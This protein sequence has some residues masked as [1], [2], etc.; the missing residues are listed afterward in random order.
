MARSD[1]PRAEAG[2]SRIGRR[3][4]AALDDGNEGYK[5][6][7]EELFRVAATIFKEKGY[8]AATLNDIA[9]RIGSDRASLYYYVSGK[10]EL[11]REVVR[12]VL[13]GNVAEA[14]R[15][16][17]LDA[18]P[19]EKL[20]LLV[21]QLVAS[22]EHHY[23]YMYVYIQEDM[24]R[25]SSEHSEWAQ[26]MVRQTHRFERATI[27]IIAEGV[28]DGTFRG[29]VPVSLAANALFGMVNWTHRWFKPGR[30]P[31]APQVADAFWK[32]FYEGMLAPR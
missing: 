25:V 22:Y 27:K 9:E 23:P 13:D 29:D 6:K 16:L 5:T 32:V 24:Q 3:R 18:D 30:Q 1:R 26:K 17:R 4:Q 8:E 11:F 12:G 10:E 14:E 19:S 15:I 31:N 28:E 20:R 2:E 21:E 7:R